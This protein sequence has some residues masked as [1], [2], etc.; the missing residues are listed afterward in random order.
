MEGGYFRKYRKYMNYPAYRAKGMMIG[1]GPVESA[2]KVV[3]GQRMKLA[4]MRWT[5][6]G[7]DV[8]L[9]ARTALLFERAWANRGRFTCSVG[10]IL[11]TLWN[12][13]QKKINACIYFIEAL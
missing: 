8:V 11:P 5:K 2:C 12:Y 10:R 3:V 13:T 4:G 1:S 9:A 6:D 7:A